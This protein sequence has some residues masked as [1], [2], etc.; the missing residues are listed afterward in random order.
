MSGPPVSRYCYMRDMLLHRRKESQLWLFTVVEKKLPWPEYNM[1]WVQTLHRGTDIYKLMASQVN[2][3]ALCTAHWLWANGPRWGV[4]KR[5]HCGI[6]GVVLIAWPSRLKH[7]ERPGVG[8]RGI[9]DISSR[10]W[11]HSCEAF[12]GCLQLPAFFPQLLLGTDLHRI[13]WFSPSPDESSSPLTRPPASQQS[14]FSKV[15]RVSAWDGISPVWRT[16]GKISESATP[17]PKKLL[18][19]HSPPPFSFCSVVLELLLTKWF[20]SVLWGEWNTDVSFS[21]S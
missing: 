1:N 2:A 14:L 21:R 6:F 9:T 15:D 20:W 17:F 12:T 19:I 11:V 13:P 8:L 4:A 16:H 10:F 5:G 3:S 18:L 7:G